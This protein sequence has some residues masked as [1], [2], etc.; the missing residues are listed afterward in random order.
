MTNKE[1][2]QRAVQAAAFTAMHAIDDGAS[3]E[4]VIKIAVMTFGHSI[5][6]IFKNDLSREEFRKGYSD[7]VQVAVDFGE[8]LEVQ[9][10]GETH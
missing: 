2:N 8:Q 1:I 9:R 10:F 7:A 5:N 3:V 6:T 4:E